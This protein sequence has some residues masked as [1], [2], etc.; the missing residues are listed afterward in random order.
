M[1]RGVRNA[2]CHKQP[3]ALC[4]HRLRCLDWEDRQISSI[5][6]CLLMVIFEE[7]AIVLFPKEEGVLRTVVRA[8]GFVSFGP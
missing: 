2:K 1:S 7:V 6:V 4:I 8:I 3:I 5:M